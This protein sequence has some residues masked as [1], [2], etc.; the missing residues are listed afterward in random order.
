[1]TVKSVLMRLGAHQH[2]FC[3]NFKP[4]VLKLRGAKD[5]QGGRE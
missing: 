1:M 4:R 2:T 3:S 5:L